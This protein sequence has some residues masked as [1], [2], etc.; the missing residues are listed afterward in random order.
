MS[1]QLKVRMQDVLGNERARSRKD[2]LRYLIKECGFSKVGAATNPQQIEVFNALADRWGQQDRV[3]DLLNTPGVKITSIEDNAMKD[4]QILVNDSAFTA[5][6]LTAL[7]DKIH[8]DNVAAGWWSDIKTGQSTLHTRNVPEMLCLI[9]S[10]ISEAMEGHRK[11]LMDDKLAHRPML[12]VELVDAM[13]RI[14]DLAGSR[15]AI[16]RE[17]DAAFSSDVNPIGDIFE[18]KRAFNANRADHKI[19]NRVKDGGKAF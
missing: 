9:H 1:D 7:A 14:L 13:I 17:D 11:K 10:E 2:T 5:A 3:A 16:E 12:Q 4:I 18:E 15:M 8:A 6:F 19:A